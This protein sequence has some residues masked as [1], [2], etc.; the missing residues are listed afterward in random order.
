MKSAYIS[1]KILQKEKITSNQN[2]PGE[3]L[4]GTIEE[5]IQDS[6]VEV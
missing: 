5:A 2:S 1:Q 4:Q 6:D 3:V